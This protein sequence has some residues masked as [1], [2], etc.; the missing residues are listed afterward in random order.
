[1]NPLHQKLEQ[2]RGTHFR[3]LS[4]DWV[5]IDILYDD[6]QVV[7]Q[8]H[9]PED[10]NPL[11]SSQYGEVKRRIPETVSLPISDEDNLGFSDALMLLLQGRVK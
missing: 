11:Q 5:L 10:A 4:D 9:K 3:Y 8:R 2:L 7:L 1:M 6:D